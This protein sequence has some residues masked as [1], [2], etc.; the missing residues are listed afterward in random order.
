MFFNSI[1]VQICNFDEKFRGEYLR[2]VQRQ[3]LSSKGSNNR[4]FEDFKGIHFYRFK[5]Y[6]CQRHHEFRIQHLFW[7]Y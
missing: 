7:F 1:I 2:N 5:Q 3:S 6:L 4:N